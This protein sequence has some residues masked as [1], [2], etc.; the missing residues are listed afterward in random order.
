MGMKNLIIIFAMN[1]ALFSSDTIQLLTEKWIPY[2]M[3]DENGFSGISI[4][5]V[6]EI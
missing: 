6:K 3:E 5:L 2:Q 1:I 4:D